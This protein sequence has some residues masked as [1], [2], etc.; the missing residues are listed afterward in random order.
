MLSR[1]A[2]L[3]QRTVSREIVA[4]SDEDENGNGELL[5]VGTSAG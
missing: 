5:I 1:E 2:T 3:R 4:L